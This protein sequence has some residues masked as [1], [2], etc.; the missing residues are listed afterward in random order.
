MA[1]KPK[2]IFYF[3]GVAMASLSFFS[4]GIKDQSFYLALAFG[5]FAIS[6]TD[7]DQKMFSFQEIKNIGDSKIQISLPGKLLEAISFA[8]ALVWLVSQG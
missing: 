2:I 5:S 8:L 6:E 7:I 1:R 4:S 3:L